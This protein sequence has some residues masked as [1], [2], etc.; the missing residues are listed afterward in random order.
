M[1]IFQ[2][3][4]FLICDVFII[5][6]M[7]K[8]ALVV[9]NSIAKNKKPKT[10]ESLIINKDTP[11]D[12]PFEEFFNQHYTK[13]DFISTFRPAFRKRFPCADNFATVLDKPYPVYFLSNIFPT[14][15]LKSVKRTLEKST[16]Y[17]KS[18]DLYEFYQ[19]DDLKNS[20]EPDL[21]KLRETIYSPQFVR[22]ISN[23]TGIE[24]DNT[25]DLSAHQYAFGNY[26]LCHD[27]DIKDVDSSRGRRIAFIFYLV[28]E[29]WSEKDGGALEF[30][31]T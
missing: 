8:H 28:D 3:I 1:I 7:K 29:D 20:L 17:K 25:P 26:L 30:F 13:P 22:L 15:F 11:L 18:N 5:I 9:D 21:I 10:S 23:L 12:Q 16:F 14:E 24:L 31:D 6:I 19:S 2:Q 27:D 4:L